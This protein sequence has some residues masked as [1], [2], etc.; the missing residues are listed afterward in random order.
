MSIKRFIAEKDT[1][2]TDAFKENLTTRGINSNMGVADS[3][4]IFSIYGQANT[5]SLEKSRILVQFPINDISASRAAGKLPTSGNVEFYLRL[6]NVVHP[7]SVPRDFSMTIN[8][9]SRSWDE[10]YG[11]DMEGYTDNGFVSGVGGFGTTWVSPTSGTYWYNQ[12]GDFYTGSNYNLTASFKTGLEDIELNIT[13]LT[14]EWISETLPNYGLLIKLSSSFEDGST[15]GSFYTKKFSARGSQYYFSRPC[16]E[17]RWNPSVTDDRNNFYASSVLLSPEDNTMNLYFYN[18]VGGELKNVYGNPDIDIKFYTDA[19]LNNELSASSSIIT[20]PLPGVY[21]ASVIIDTTASVLY[22]KW[23]NSLTSS[24]KYHSSSFDV[25]QRESD[26]FSNLPE[27]IV[28]LT[29]AKSTYNKGEL[30]RF[31]IFVRER[32]WQP[33][34]YSVAYNNVENTAIP[35]LY[36]KIFRLNDN[37]TIIDYSTGSLAYTKTSYDS[38]GNYFELDMNILEKDYGYGIKL[39]T[40]D[41]RQ[42]NEFKNTYKF[43][44][45]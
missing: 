42:L 11:L 4:E 8:P 24:I 41:G 19:Q 18:K 32:D 28:H 31:N 29:N 1:T 10:G 43:R 12:G 38:N 26:D 27:Y 7:F 22:D 20:N 15:L 2:I 33:N 3:L 44:I 36:Y 39:A 45:D 16:I 17:A 6:Y 9:L 21:K 14:E 30:A 40:W 34:I 25:Y 35:N 13:S 5:S 23:T 37:Y